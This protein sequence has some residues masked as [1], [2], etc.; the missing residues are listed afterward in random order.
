MYLPKHGR[1]L[2][3]SAGVSPAFWRFVEISKTT[4]ET[5]ALQWRAVRLRNLSHAL[6]KARAAAVV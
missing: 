6:Q 1:Q 4:G 5:L 3:R 2:Y